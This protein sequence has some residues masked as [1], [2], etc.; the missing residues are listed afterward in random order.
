M[1]IHDPVVSSPASS[2]LPVLSGQALRV[3]FLGA[4]TPWVYALAEALANQGHQVGAI[5]PFDTRT[6]KR[7]QPKWPNRQPPSNLQ[8]QFWVYPPGYVG[9]LAPLFSPL[10]RARLNRSFPP[11]TEIESR[12]AAPW[13]IAPYPWAAGIT[14]A[15]PS[16]RLIYYNL[17]DY[18]LYQPERAA[19]IL[20]Q[21][22]ELV[23]RAALTICLAQT[24]VDSLRARFPERAE[25]ILHFPLG[26]VENLLNPTP[27]KVPNGRVVGYIGN[28]IDRVDWRLVA[29]VASRVPDVKFHFIGGLDGFSGGG[30]DANWEID[31]D[32]ALAL[33]NVRHLGPIVQDDVGRYYWNFDLNWIPYDLGHAFNQAS[34]PTK[35]MDGLASGR[36]VLS[37]DVP[38]CRLYQDHISIFRSV[39]EAVSQIQRSLAKSTAAAAC[40]QVEF[41]REHHTWTT[42]AQWLNSRLQALN[43]N[44]S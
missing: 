11:A 1:K 18:V 29:A 5:A 40:T 21:E 23:R 17:D 22:G 28:L 43:S 13:I 8:R 26:A 41:V 6:F 34:C 20:S 39:D 31:R 15:I 37:T 32:K 38:E 4:G 25:S 33:P 42:R 2:T 19:S 14:R 30:V 9:T 12:D 7:L 10:L 44:L 35:I 27:S 24:Q 36:P 16:Q 3:L